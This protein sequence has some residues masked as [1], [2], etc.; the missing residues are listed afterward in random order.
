MQTLV[1]LLKNVSAKRRVSETLKLAHLSVVF[2]VVTR[3][4]AIHLVL[5]VLLYQ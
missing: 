4:G 2:V 5:C 3:C 1:L